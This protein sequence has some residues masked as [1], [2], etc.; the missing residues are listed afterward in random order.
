MKTSFS[1]ALSLLGI[2]AIAAGFNSCKVDERYSSEEI[3]KTDLTVTLFQNGL[4]VPLG[5]VDTIW[6]SDLVDK[7]VPEDMSD[8]LQKSEDGYFIVIDGNLDASDLLDKVDIKELLNADG[9]SVKDGSEFSLGD[10][11]A[12]DLSF[13]ATQF[14][15]EYE[16]PEFSSVTNPTLPSFHENF[17]QAAGLKDVNLDLDIKIESKTQ[18]QTVL[19]KSAIT[20]AAN[21]AD[22]LGRTEFDLSG[23]VSSV[24]VEI[25]AFIIPAFDKPEQINSIESVKLMDGAGVRLSLSLENGIFSK[26]TLTPNIAVDLSD[27][28]VLADGSST[29]NLS[30]LALSEDNGYAASTLVGIRSINTA[31][32]FNEKNVTFSGAVEFSNSPTA[33]TSVAKSVTGDMALVLKI[34]FVDFEVDDL[35]AEINP[36]QVA[37]APTNYPIIM[38]PVSLPDEV[39]SVERIIFTDASAITLDINVDNAEIVPDL[40]LTADLFKVTFPSEL[41][42][43]G[44]GV[45]GN[46]FTL[47]S[48]TSVKNHIQRTIYVRGINL[49]APVDQRI[50]FNGNV[51]V[52]AALTAAGSV[53]T[54]KILNS[55]KD[56][57]VTAKIDGAF[58][59]QDIIATIAGLSQ[60]ID[61]P[62]KSFEINNIDPSI[63]NFGT[64]TITP[65]LVG[66]QLPELVIDVNI[67]DFGSLPVG[68]GDGIVI[69]LPDVIQFAELEPALNHDPVNHTV[70]IK[71]VED[72]T[73]VLPIQNLTITPQ[74]AADGTYFVRSVFGVKGG[75]AVSEGQV[76]LSE[77]TA[78]S[79]QKIAVNATTPDIK[80]KTIALESIEFEIPQYKY[81]IKDLISM[82]QIPEMVKKVTEVDLG[83]I[84]F[85]LNLDV[86]NLP[87]IGAGS[88]DVDLKVS[89]PAF[90]Y[91]L[92]ENNNRSNSITIK[93]DISGGHLDFT[94]KV[95]L[96]LSNYD[97][98]RMRDLHQE[99][100]GEVVLS[101]KVS[102]VNP[103]VDITTITTDEPVKVDYAV[104]LG[105]SDGKICLRKIAGLISYSMDY[106]TSMDIPFD[107]FPKELDN[108]EL[109]LPIVSLIADVTANTAIPVGLTAELVPVKNGEEVPGFAQ[110]LQLEAP[111]TL[112]HTTPTVK[113]NEVPIDF[114]DIF[115]LRPSSVN[116]NV[117][118]AIDATRECV[119][120]PAADYAV[121]L[122]YSAE[123][124]FAFGEK[125]RLAI[126]QELDIASISEYLKYTSLGLKLEIVNTLPFG[127]K[128]G[129]DLIR[130]EDNE[131]TVVPME[132]DLKFILPA[133]Q[134]SMN[135]VV[136]QPEKGVQTDNIKKL[137]ITFEISASGVNLTPEDYL[138]V[139]NVVAVLPEGISVNPS[140]F[141][142]N[143]E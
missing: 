109:D 41:I 111:Y 35:V 79:G 72:H 51:S 84:A 70:T 97:F 90:V 81:E 74:K 62:E 118:A 15:E 29:L 66:G 85:S 19:P 4:E 121:A 141:I 1:K 24:P 32:L 77:I 28:L 13:E 112:D 49:P 20:T 11:S 122:D 44:E 102:A 3:L 31:K 30:A 126:E 56:L 40:D 133:G 93:K 48:G 80:A 96:D 123:I 99:F 42:V 135:E 54:K 75:I 64:F 136:I 114:N 91:A 139:K 71:T 115:N 5:S 10:F 128:M 76:N 127:V 108:M 103:S 58:E 94:R 2:A 129:M 107:Q 132:K 105:D 50:I 27:V 60:Q 43:E 59:L 82:N 89:L 131:E 86:T 53:S 110:T 9:I 46:T 88:F 57:S 61:I 104:M 16:I 142:N 120:Y 95:G 47:P 87:D 117:H 26:G 124:P 101:G 36:I 38:D 113:H 92:D 78:L 55:A 138:F 143:K 7:Y 14:G 125:T 8:I 63:G 22:A 100:E 67:P 34:T 68:V 37:P 39:K 23:L 140:D 130:V 33:K 137:K 134:T 25:P 73:Y 12:D 65:E 119:I 6:V 21:A 116:L 18:K 83:D 98:D 52:E 45:S 17:S 106:T 69:T